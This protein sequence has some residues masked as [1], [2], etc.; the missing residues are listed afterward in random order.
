[1]AGDEALT[2]ACDAGIAI[3]P[4]P[5][6]KEKIEIVVVSGAD[7]QMRKEVIHQIACARKRQEKA[8]CA[9]IRKAAAKRAAEAR[10]K[11]NNP[12][13]PRQ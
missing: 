13:R 11:G 1:M 5:P 8:G 6:E 4:A 2:A 9:R 3:E 7:G 10:R 12:R